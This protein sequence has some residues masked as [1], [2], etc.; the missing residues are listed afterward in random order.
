[1]YLLH[2]LSG[3][4]ANPTGSPTKH[5]SAKQRAEEPWDRVLKA[6][7]HHPDAGEDQTAKTDDRARVHGK[8]L[9]RSHQ[10]LRPGEVHR[11]LRLRSGCDCEEEE[12]WSQGAQRAKS[13]SLR[14]AHQGRIGSGIQR[15][16]GEGF[17]TEWT[18]NSWHRSTSAD[19]VCSSARRKRRTSPTLAS[20]NLEAF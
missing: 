4:R 10:G 9:E 14:R 19:R 17:P 13:R 15:P 12:T 5:A 20:N 8:G 7:R 2:R 3:Q 11:A 6:A 18:A 16:K 1:M